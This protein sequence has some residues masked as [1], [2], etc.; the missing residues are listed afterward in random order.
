MLDIVKL[1]NHR[2]TKRDANLPVSFYKNFTLTDFLLGFLHKA[3][4]DGLF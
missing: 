3:L 4:Q 2:L 1:R